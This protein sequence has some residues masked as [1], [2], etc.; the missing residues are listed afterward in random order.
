MMKDKA[1]ATIKEYCMIN[2][3]DTVAVCLSGGADSM[4]LFHFLCS[5][6]E[7]LKIK[8]MALHVNHGL[9]KESK[10]EEVWVKEYCRQMGA[11]CV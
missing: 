4:A 5:E 7:H 8:V 6:R 10:E 2:E 1:L 9:R 3:D 11:E